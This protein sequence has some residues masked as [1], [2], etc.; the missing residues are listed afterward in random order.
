MNCPIW[1]CG[2]LRNL[3]SSCCACSQ[4]Y[5]LCFLF[6]DHLLLRDWIQ[7]TGVHTLNLVDCNLLTFG[8]IICFAKLIFWKSGLPDICFDVV[9]VSQN[10]WCCGWRLALDWRKNSGRNTIFLVCGSSSQMICVT[11]WKNFSALTF[12]NLSSP[13]SW[14]SVSSVSGIDRL[15]SRYLFDN[16]L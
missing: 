7:R 10:Y 3:S 12:F 14:R 4:C 5:F 9:F 6:L 8:K 15:S 16:F 1:W 2:R 11:L 13:D